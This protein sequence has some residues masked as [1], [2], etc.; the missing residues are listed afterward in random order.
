MGSLAG[1]FRER[2]RKR[3]GNALTLRSRR[4]A[5]QGARRRQRI[6]RRSARRYGRNVIATPFDVLRPNG[7]GAHGPALHTHNAW[8]KSGCPMI[9]GASGIGISAAALPDG[10]L[11]KFRPFKNV[12]AKRSTC[13]VMPSASGSVPP[14]LG[15]F[16]TS[17]RPSALGGAFVHVSAKS[18][19]GTVGAE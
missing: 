5:A 14:K 4:A 13:S 17:P 6:A 11:K 9:A 7:E 19:F 10:S 15:T 16:A 18:G 3:A 2:P 12:D 1:R 8:A